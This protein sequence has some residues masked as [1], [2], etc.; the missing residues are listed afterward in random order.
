MTQALLYSKSPC[1]IQSIAR[2]TCPS[3]VE[4][5]SYEA[6]LLQSNNLNATVTP[7]RP[8]ILTPNDNA[9]ATNIQ[10]IQ[11]C[12]P[13]QQKLL[14]GL[15]LHAGGTA[16]LGLASLL[17]DTKIP[18]V[19]GDMNTFGGNGIGAAIAKSSPVISAI[20]EYDEALQAYHDLSNH[21][22]AP[23]SVRAA[24]AR[25][26]RAFNTMNRQFNRAALPYLNNAEY[27]MRKAKTV[28][29]KEVWES[30]P[31]RDNADVIKLEKLTKVG[32]IAGPGIIALDGY[33]RANKVNHM[34]REDNPEWKR[35]AFIQSGAFGAGILAGAVIGA[36]IALTPGGILIALV[37]GGIAGVVSDRIA[38]SALGNL[39]DLL[40]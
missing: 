30:I 37:A 16:T 18:D 14:A 6:R 28:T 34:R 39:H 20:A 11:S 10:R 38:Q 9:R 15:S 5:E 32:R 29:G 26:E 25:A 12:S 35:E 21:R 23:R 4:P 22:A 8:T 36:V 13:E 31:V 33:L 2:A 27:K 40:F 3:D 19:I 24:K 17:W 7:L 1:S